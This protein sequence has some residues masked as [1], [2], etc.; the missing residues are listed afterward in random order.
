MCLNVLIV[1]LMSDVSY[2]GRHVS[3]LR[4]CRCF[5]SVQIASEVEWV[6]VQ[7]VNERVPE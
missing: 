3:T 4:V 5:G 7:C 1:N 2:R 6:H